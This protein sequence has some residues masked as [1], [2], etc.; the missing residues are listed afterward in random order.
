MRNFV[1]ILSSLTL[2]T[3]VWVSNVFVAYWLTNTESWFWLDKVL[4]FSG[5]TTINCTP[6]DGIVWEQETLFSAIQNYIGYLIW[7]LYV[8]AT[9][10]WIYW[11]FT[12]L[13]SL[14]DDEKVKKWKT[15][16]IRACIWI[17]VIF[18]AGAIVGFVLQSLDKGKPSTEIHSSW[19]SD[20][21]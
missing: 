15:I 17:V 6:D 5:V 14:W 21:E 1:T 9:I 10:Y 16:I 20:W 18:L 19:D 11:W 8:L 13:N 3:F 2:F 4:C 7:F 12:I